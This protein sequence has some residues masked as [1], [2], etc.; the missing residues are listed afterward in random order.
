MNNLYFG[1]WFEYNFDTFALAHNGVL[2]TASHT[3]FLIDYGADDCG[4]KV[5]CDAAPYNDNEI[6]F[7]VVKNVRTTG[8]VSEHAG[9]PD[10]VDF[11][12]SRRSEVG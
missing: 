10:G 9:P 5:L 4:E 7:V 1:Y 3:L 6:E 12:L 8:V 2:A 11:I